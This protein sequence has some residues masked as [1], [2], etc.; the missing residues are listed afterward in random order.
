M[1]KYLNI[2]TVYVLLLKQHP[3]SLF[4][5]VLTFRPLNTLLET[6]SLQHLMEI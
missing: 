5:T 4:N 6:A 1:T 2:Y 3:Y